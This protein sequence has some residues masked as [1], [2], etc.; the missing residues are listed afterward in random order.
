MQEQ[1]I[2]LPEM[3]WEKLTE[4]PGEGE[5]KL[6]RDQEPAKGRTLLVRLHAGAQITPH[7]HIGAVQH[8]ILEGEYESGGKIYGA[9]TYRLLPGHHGVA[10]IS[11]QNGVTI[12]MIYDPLG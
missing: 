5:A 3:P 9:G 11:T 8:Y 4:F 2:Y 6:L 1:T 12:L 7:S 10:D